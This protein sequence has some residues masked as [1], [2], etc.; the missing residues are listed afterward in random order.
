MVYLV[1]VL[2]QKLAFS[3]A[4]PGYATIVCLILLLGAC[5]SSFWGFWGEYIGRIYIQ[6]KQ[7]PVYLVK[8]H[9]TWEASPDQGGGGMKGLWN[10]LWNSSLVRFGLVGVLNTVVGTTIMFVL[11]NKLHCTY[12]QSSF[13]NYFF[14]SILSFFLNKYFTFRSKQRSWREVV[15]FVIN[16]AVCYLLAYGISSP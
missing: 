5:S 12:W 14:G 4:V 7:R 11:Y 8:E 10:K 13:A 3:I 6:V 2:V 16:I 15:R 1:V 9:L